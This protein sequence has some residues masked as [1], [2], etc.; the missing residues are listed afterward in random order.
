[1]PRNVFSNIHNVVGDGYVRSE[2]VVAVLLQK[3]KNAKRIYAHVLAAGSNCD[4]Y[5]DEGIT[6]PSGPQQVK[7]FT[8]VAQLAGIDA[9][10]IDFMEAHGSATRVCRNQNFLMP[11]VHSRRMHLAR[12]SGESCPN[13]DRVSATH[14][15]LAESSQFWCATRGD[16]QTRHE[17]LCLVHQGPLKTWDLNEPR[18]ECRVYTRIYILALALSRVPSARVYSRHNTILMKRRSWGIVYIVSKSA[19][20]VTL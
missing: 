8:K 17:T 3:A 14:Y 2:G 6:F 20:V 9:N 15:T 10:T 7:L 11:A 12:V 5:K 16:S 1:M 4:G 18:H 19:A 13:W